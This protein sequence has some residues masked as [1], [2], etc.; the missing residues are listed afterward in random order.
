MGTYWATARRVTAALLGL[1]MVALIA[2]APAQAAEYPGGRRIYSVALG[3]VPANGD[4]ATGP[5]WVRLAMYYFYADGTIRES[6]WYW[7]HATAVGDARTG[8]RTTG[9]AGHDCEV[10]TA[11]NF[12]PTAAAKTLNGTWTTSGDTT[13]ISWSE[14]SVETWRASDPVSDLTRLDLVGS[15]YGV[16]EGWGFGSLASNDTYTPISSVPLKQ[17]RGEYAAYNNVRGYAGPSQ[18]DLQLFSRCSANCLSRLSEPT[19]ACSACP[20][21][22]SS[23][24]VRYYL[25]GS[26]RRNFYEHWCTCLTSAACYTGGSH[27]K[28]Q[29][30]VIG[31]NGTFHGWIGVEASNFTANTGYFAV[32]Y[33]LDF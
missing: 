17:Y 12:E 9:C 3:S 32:H 13:T 8:Y 2:P 19:T 21:G 18:M 16:T 6:F 29:L 24:P 27:R 22:A 4:P 23:S 15:N 1:M 5:V 14:G 11:K 10:R 31:D 33:H 20:T 28:P 26:G 25:A 30:Q 7:N